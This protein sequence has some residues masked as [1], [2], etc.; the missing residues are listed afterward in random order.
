MLNLWLNLRLSRD[1]VAQAY[2]RG[3]SKIDV[4]PILIGGALL[5]LGIIRI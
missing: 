5:T 2:A 3:T 4:V 1:W